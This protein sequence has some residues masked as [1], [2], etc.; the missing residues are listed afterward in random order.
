QAAFE[1][2]RGAFNREVF[3]S[4][5]RPKAGAPGALGS[6]DAMAA[7]AERRWDG[8]KPAFLR[9]QHAGDAAGF[10]EIRRSPRDEVSMNRDAVYC[11]AA[12]GEVLGSVASKPVAPVQRFIAGI[13]FVQF[14]NWVLRWLYFAGG[15]AGCVMIATGFVFW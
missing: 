10:V 3:G 12:S 8:G 6:L 13:H 15:L 7:E 1:G 5:Q 2:D 9:V 11:D 4:Y 14:D